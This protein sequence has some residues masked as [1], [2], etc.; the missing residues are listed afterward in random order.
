MEMNII[1]ILV[2]LKKKVNE[3]C[4]KKFLLLILRLFHIC[5]FPFGIHVPIGAAIFLRE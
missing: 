5:A 2:V 3:K 4:T 1:S